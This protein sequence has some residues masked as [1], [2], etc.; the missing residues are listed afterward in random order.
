MSSMSNKEHIEALLEQKKA[1]DALVD[2]LVSIISELEEK[3]LNYQE[4]KYIPYL[5]MREHPELIPEYVELAYANEPAVAKMV[6]ES[7]HDE[8]FDL[9]TLECTGT[10]FKP[11]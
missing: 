3:I 9:S 8:T 10:D 4:A 7:L 5:L 11:W 6:V 2:A 1:N